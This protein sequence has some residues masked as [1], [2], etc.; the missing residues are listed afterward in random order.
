MAEAIFLGRYQAVR[1]LGAGGMG[2]VYLGKQ[3]DS[4]RPVVIKVMHDDLAA[5]PRY[6]RSFLREMELMKR[7]H[8]PHAVALYDASEGDPLCIVM[9]YVDGVTLVELLER[10]G[11][12]IPERVGRL[13]VQLCQVLQAAHNQGILHRDLTTSNVM[14]AH[15]GTPDESLKVMDFGLARPGGAAGPYIAL[16]KLTGSGNSIGGGTPDYIC[17]EQIRG[18]PVDHRGDLYS[19]GVLVYRLLVGRLPFEEAEGIRGIL[20]AHLHKDP[21][22]FAHFGAHDV[23]AAIEAVV[24]DCLAKDPMDRPDCAKE[25]AMRYQEALGQ[26]LFPPADIEDPRGA[27]APP[28]L[29]TKHF[30]ADE[31]ADVVEAWMPEQIAVVKL[32]GFAE[33]CG[34]EIIDSEPGI[35]RVRLPAPG[36]PAEAAPARGFLGWLGLGKKRAS[37]P[38]FALMELHMANKPGER[39]TV[40]EI[41]VT[42][43]P[44]NAAQLPATSEWQEWR[45]QTCRAL[46]GYLMSK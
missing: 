23:P 27:N 22:P 9:E 38:C 17:P 1:Q 15:P 45:E 29:E 30:Q 44:E 37:G 4:G 43:H 19:V 34:G 28:P 25:L 14:I 39:Q 18:E 42:I 8:H 35:V 10:V 16:E 21:P 5:D 20:Q 26:S 12:L 24:R 3:L 6:R 40:L 7:F 46:R 32:R 36:P 13:L 11:R 2:R 31:L 41:T 33:D